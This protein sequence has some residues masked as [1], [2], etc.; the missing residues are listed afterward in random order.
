MYESSLNDFWLL[1]RGR[2]GSTHS[3]TCRPILHVYSLPVIPVA[4]R[5]RSIHLGAAVSRRPHCGRCS[6]RHVHGIVLGRLHRLCRRW[7]Y[8]CIPVTPILLQV[9][10]EGTSTH[11]FC[12][13]QRNWIWLQRNWMWSYANGSCQARIGFLFCDNEPKASKLV[14]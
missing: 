1:R 5:S 11:C 9:P 6:G 2:C 13:L 14:T 4:Q 3:V 12:W 10:R 8:R 7:E